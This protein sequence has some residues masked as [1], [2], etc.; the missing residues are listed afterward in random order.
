MRTRLRENY[1]NIDAMEILM[2]LTVKLLVLVFLC[3][4]M[5]AYAEIPADVTADFSVVSGTVVM[6]INDEYIVDLDDRNNLNIGDIL[7]VVAP[8]K[9]ILHP[10]TGKVLGS[11]DNVLGF[12]QVTR[13]YSGYS[14]A[15]VLSENLAPENGAP[16]KRF[17]QVPALFVD[18]SEDA[19]DLTAD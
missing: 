10:E 1:D 9:K 8:G 12:L 11:I 16:V 7:T 6:P 19:R 13:I 18:N 15:K 2:K 5:R 14:Y 3:L 4:P 17:E